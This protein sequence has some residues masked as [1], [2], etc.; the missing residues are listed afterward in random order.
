MESNNGDLATIGSFGE[1]LRR[2]RH[3]MALTQATLACSSGCA[4]VTIRKIEDGERRPSRTLALRLAQSLEIAEEKRAR[5]IACALGE[6]N[7]DRLLIDLQSPT[8]MPASRRHTLPSLPPL[9][10]RR[11]EIQEIIS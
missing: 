4:T 2:R 6:L 8:T 7:V 3:E 11:R 10:G 1:W 5:F 9:V